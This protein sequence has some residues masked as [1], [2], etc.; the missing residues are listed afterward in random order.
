[1][2]PIADTIARASWHGEG[3]GDCDY[4]DIYDDIGSIYDSC[5][6]YDYR[7]DDHDDRRVFFLLSP[8]I[9]GCGAGDCSVLIGGLLSG[10]GGESNLDSDSVLI[11]VLRLIGSQMG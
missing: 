7:S 6:D 4:D 10:Q 5:D 2:L 8:A 11:G 3:C 9:R 1:M